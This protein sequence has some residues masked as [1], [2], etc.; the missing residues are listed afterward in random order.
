[1]NTRYLLE[2]CFCIEQFQENRYVHKTTFLSGFRFLIIF[3][4]AKTSHKKYKICTE[5]F[6]MRQH[7][8][9]KNSYH[10]T[11]KPRKNL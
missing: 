7:R 8:I 9:F 1:M 11:L 3:F 5:L 2:F 4:V 6:E 10:V